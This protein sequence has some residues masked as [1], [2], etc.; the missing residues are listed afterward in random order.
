MYIVV[1]REFGRTIYRLDYN[2]GADILEQNAKEKLQSII[3]V[4]QFTTPIVKL[5]KAHKRAH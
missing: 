3:I 5:T 1:D 2:R 4:T